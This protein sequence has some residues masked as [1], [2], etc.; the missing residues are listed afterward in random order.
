MAYNV[1]FLK[2]TSA[3]Y[4]AI[5]KDTNTFYYV[6]GKDLYL[7]TTKLSNNADLAAALLRIGINEANIG[8]LTDLTT[9]KKN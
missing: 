3:E 1:K 6:D 7:G 8:T 5:T 4:A 9:T 2:G